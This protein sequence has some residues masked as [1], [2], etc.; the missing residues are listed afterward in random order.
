MGGR[1][2]INNKC[3]EYC[4]VV[5]YESLIVRGTSPCALLHAA[6]LKVGTMTNMSS[7]VFPCHL[8]YPCSL[9]RGQSQPKETIKSGENKANVIL[10]AFFSNIFHRFWK[11]VWLIKFK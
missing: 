3:V 11:Y 4:D 8:E 6:L 1:S 9:C 5:C 7:C 10:G 2:A